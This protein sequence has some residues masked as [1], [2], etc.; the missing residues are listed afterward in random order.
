MTGVLARICA[1]RRVEVEQAKRARPLGALVTAAASAPACRGFAAALAAR[2]ATSRFALIA[3]LKRASPSRGLIRADFDPAAIA[4]AYVDGGATCLSVLT[5]RK[6][7]Q[8][9]DAFLAMVRATVPV[10]LLRK[11]FI[12]DPYQVVEARLLGADCILLIMAALDDPTVAEL[13]AA[14]GEFGLDVLVEV[15]GEAELDRAL[16]LAA[17]MIGINNRNLATLTVDL[18]VTERLAPRIPTDRLIVGESGISRNEDLH[19]LSAAGVRAFLVGESLIREA[20]VAHAVRSLLRSDDSGAAQSPA[21][22]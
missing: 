20:D 17:S 22:A 21:H 16:P 15:H 8:G 10:P 7:F 14:A 18:E 6:Y 19:R 12:L 5:E 13:A 4:A 1:D 11:D 9:D 3:E 2:L